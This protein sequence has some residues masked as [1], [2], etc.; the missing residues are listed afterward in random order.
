MRLLAG[1]R[2]LAADRAMIDARANP[3]EAASGGELKAEEDIH[4]PLQGLTAG[5]ASP[6]IRSAEFRK[7]CA[8]P[9]QEP[10]RRSRFV[11]GSA[12]TA[13]TS[14]TDTILRYLSPD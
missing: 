3:R 4:P 11:A 12:R 5:R 10:Q 9:G 7:F 14:A 8:S 6:G 13:R 1:A 2:V